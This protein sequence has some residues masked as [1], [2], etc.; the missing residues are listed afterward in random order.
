MQNNTNHPKSDDAEA[1]ALFYLMTPKVGQKFPVIRPQAGWLPFFA[2]AGIRA[3]SWENRQIH[4]LLTHGENI[5]RTIFVRQ[6][7]GSCHSASLFIRLV[8]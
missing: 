3:K 6:S 5:Q 8:S 1:R 4:Y 7:E 2:I